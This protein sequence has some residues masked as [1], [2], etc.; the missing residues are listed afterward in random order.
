MFLKLMPQLIVA[1]L[2][3]GEGTLSLLLTRRAERVM[4]SITPRRCSNTSSISLGKT[5]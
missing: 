3:A 4:P 5:G 1:D 2:G